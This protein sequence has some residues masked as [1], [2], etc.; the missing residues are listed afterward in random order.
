MC[1]IICVAVTAATLASLL[2]YEEISVLQGGLEGFH[3]T[4]LNARLP[5][6]DLTRSERDAFRF[7]LRAAPQIT[8]LIK[9][10]GRVKPV[11]RSVKKAVGGCGI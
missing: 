4:I 6:R 2:G 10:R 3:A 1:Q 9:E 8:A 5:D 7:R 11:R